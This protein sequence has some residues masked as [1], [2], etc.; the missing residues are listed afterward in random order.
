MRLSEMQP[1]VDKIIGELDPN[2]IQCSQCHRYATKD[3]GRWITN[4]RLLGSDEREVLFKCDSCDKELT[5]HLEELV[6]GLDPD[7]KKCSMC[8]KYKHLS[9]YSV[10][11]YTPPFTFAM[12]NTCM[13]GQIDI[14]N[15]R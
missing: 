15:S 6:G 9:E 4:G 11:E 5:K 2:Q 10:A 13:E 3:D 7:K 12:C 1:K 14:I 8:H